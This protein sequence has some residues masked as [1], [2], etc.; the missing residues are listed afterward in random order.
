M[1]VLPANLFRLRSV[2]GFYGTGLASLFSAGSVVFGKGLGADGLLARMSHKSSTA[3]R[4][5][6]TGVDLVGFAT[7]QGVDPASPA[8]LREAHTSTRSSFA[9]YEFCETC[10]P[11]FS[12]F[13]LW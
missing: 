13:R 2:K 4:N 11:G 12:R 9:R 10:G 3:L 7:L 5:L 1:S 8:H 6:G